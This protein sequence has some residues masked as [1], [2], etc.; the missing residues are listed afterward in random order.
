MIL[1]IREEIYSFDSTP[2]S[3]T[4]FNSGFRNKD[5]GGLLGIQMPSEIRRR[6]A[7]QLLQ[8]ILNSTQF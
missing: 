6:A 3:F 4:Q 1:S 5:K 8:Q 2:I 7:L